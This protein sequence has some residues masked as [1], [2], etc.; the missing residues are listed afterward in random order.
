MPL[1]R[2]QL[3]VALLAAL[4]C[5]DSTGSG[6]GWKVDYGVLAQSPFVLLSM[7]DTVTAG[8]IVATSV[9]TVGS[10][11]CTRPADVAVVGAGSLLQTLTPR[12]SVATGNVACTDDLAM[13]PHPIQLRFN[14]PGTAT[15]RIRGYLDFQRSG[16]PGILERRV[17]VRR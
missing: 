4:A 16:E 6:F 1:G 5:A 10:S 7:P 13:R 14:E 9:I 3:A 15:I 11:S 17:V 8:A 12:D 2:G